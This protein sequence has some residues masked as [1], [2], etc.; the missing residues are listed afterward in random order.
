MSIQFEAHLSAGMA[1]FTM[2]ATAVVVISA[3]VLA[4]EIALILRPRRRWQRW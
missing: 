1:V 3:L 4:R 2:C